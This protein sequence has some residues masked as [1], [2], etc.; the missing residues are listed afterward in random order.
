MEAAKPSRERPDQIAVLFASG[1]NGIEYGA[2]CVP[3]EAH[4]WDW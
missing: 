4:P 2:F 3:P 1:R